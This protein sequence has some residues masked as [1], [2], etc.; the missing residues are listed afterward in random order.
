MHNYAHYDITVHYVVG[1]GWLLW[2]YSFSIRAKLGHIMYMLTPPHPLLEGPPKAFDEEAPTVAL[3]AQKT[4]APPYESLSPT[5]DGSK[6]ERL[7]WRAL[8]KPASGD[9]YLS[10]KRELTAP[11]QVKSQTYGLF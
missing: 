11:L 3:L 8:K 1:L 9:L 6:H 5:R 10:Q 4:E 2:L 7:F